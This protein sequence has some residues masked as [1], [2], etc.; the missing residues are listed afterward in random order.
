MQLY[1]TASAAKRPFAPLDRETARIYA[2]G[3]TVYDLPHIGNARPAVIFGLL[4][5]IL[6][7][8]WPVKYV[9]NVTDIDDK[10]IAAAAER[11]TSTSALTASMRKRYNEDMTAIG[12][13]KPEIE[14]LATAHIAQMQTL[15]TTLLEKGIAYAEKGGNIAFA[16]N[17]YKDY[18]SLSK[19]NEEAMRAGARVEVAAWKRNPKD[20]VLWKPSKVGEPGWMAATEWAKWGVKGRGRPG[21][22]IECSAMCHHFLGKVVDIHCG[23]ADLIFPHHENEQAQSC[24]CFGTDKLAEFWVHNGHITVDGRKMSKSLGNVL[25]VRG[26]LSEHK[27]EAIRYFLLAT[28]YHRPADWNE[29]SIYGAKAALDGWYQYFG[30]KCPRAFRYRAQ[31]RVH[32]RP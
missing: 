27:A 13:R 5:D 28:H 20:F 11:K 15:I 29:D 6:Q 16:V 32:R 3:P 17:R 12:A 1:D 31:P 18:G 2:C 8:R 19:R 26:L 30:R 7:L 22:H 10:I 14:P 24:S 21:W 9:R 25:T 23:G 4:A